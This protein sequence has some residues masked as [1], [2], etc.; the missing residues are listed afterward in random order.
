V[1]ALLASS[2]S[3]TTGW[4]LLRRRFAGLPTAPC[5]IGW[6]WSVTAMTEIGEEV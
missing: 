1:L 6:I 5:H 3:I 2:S 4:A